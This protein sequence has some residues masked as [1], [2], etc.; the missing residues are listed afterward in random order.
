LLESV[1]HSRK[2]EYSLKNKNQGLDLRERERGTQ[3]LV[4]ESGT[5]TGLVWWTGLQKLPPDL[6]SRTRIK[7]CFLSG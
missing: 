5:T 1:A 6:I 3:I 2:L 4:V 7:V